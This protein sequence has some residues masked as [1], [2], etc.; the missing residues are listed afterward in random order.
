MLHR[1]RH[2]RHR[3]H[4]F[5]DKHHIDAVNHHQQRHAHAENYST[6]DQN[7][8]IDQSRGGH[9]AHSA[10]R[11][12]IISQRTG[13]GNNFLIGMPVAAHIHSKISG[14]SRRNVRCPRRNAR[15]KIIGR[16]LNFTVGVDELQLDLIFVRKILRIAVRQG[17]IFIIP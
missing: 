16:H 11:Y 9:I 4:N 15:R 6:V 2:F 14:Q 5:T 12:T 3:L 7:L 10:N 13:N 1:L 8:L 17:V